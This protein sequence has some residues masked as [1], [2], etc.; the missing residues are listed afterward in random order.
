M[1]RAPRRVIPTLSEAKGRDRGGW[2][3]LIVALV[4]VCV[5]C[6]RLPRQA[7]RPAANEP[8][9]RATVV[10]IQTTMQPAN[11]TYTHTLVIANDRA[12]SSD[13]IDGWRLFDFR[14]KSVT[15]VDD[16]AK[17]YRS[18]PFAEVVASHRAALARPLPEGMP[19]AQFVAGGA[20]KTL[21]G[22]PSKQSMIRIGAYQRE[23]WIASHPLIP[24]GLFAIM[25]ASGPVSS[26][27]AGV[28]RAAGEALLIVQGYP[29]ADHAELPYENR[30][31]I[32][33][34]TVV[35][36]EQRVVPAA[37]LNVSSA[38]KEVKPAPENEKQQQSK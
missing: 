14:Q 20:E 29:L 19:H 21:Q 1:R 13:E 8:T 12:R 28:M 31:L 24:P 3:A 34:N 25:Q 35:K 10:T 38:Y 32:V 18:V 22:V 33:D 6:N 2:A 15:F 9:V 4:T 23:L 16:L 5:S 17:T 27:L 36:I 30:K 11:K 7:S 37:W 26:P